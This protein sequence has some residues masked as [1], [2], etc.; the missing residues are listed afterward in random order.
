MNS[1]S[2]IPKKIAS[3][4][5]FVA[6]Y[7]GDCDDWVTIKKQILL[8]IP[9]PMRKNFSTRDARTKEQSLNNFEREL[10]NYYKEITGTTLILR[11]LEE[12][13]DLNYG[14]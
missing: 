10:I 8:G 5:I 12:R 9:S 1:A 13:R 7:V 2:Q 4:L 6:S 14:F 11:T 3:Q